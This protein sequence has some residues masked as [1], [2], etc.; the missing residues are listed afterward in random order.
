MRKSTTVR[1]ACLLAA[2]SPW[3]AGMAQGAGFSQGP[4][5]APGAAEAFREGPAASAPPLQVGQTAADIRG[6]GAD[7]APLRLSQFKGRVILLDVSA[8][9][10]AFCKMDAPAVQYLYQA[11]GPKG[12]AVVTC[13]AEDSNGAVVTP[14]GLRQWTSDYHLTQKV[15]NDP[16]GTSGGVAERAYVSVTGGF[17][18]LVVID[19]AF[20][21]QYLQGGL[22]L[23]AVTGKIQALL[24]E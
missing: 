20:K 16:S 6:I 18:T 21:V 9:W 19:K 12:L 3:G 7:G 22:D 24:A 2:L 1:A 10:C 13:L 17:P 4:K 23:A 11:Y 14:S 5:A 15:M 8:M